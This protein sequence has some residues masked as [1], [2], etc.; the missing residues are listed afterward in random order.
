MT[1]KTREHEF[2][3]HLFVTGNSFIRTDENNTFLPYL[4][5]IDLPTTSQSYVRSNFTYRTRMLQLRSYRQTSMYTRTILF[6][7]V[8]VEPM[9]INID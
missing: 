8:N 7:H 1:K 9:N 3:Y 6:N 2:K 4:C 5:L